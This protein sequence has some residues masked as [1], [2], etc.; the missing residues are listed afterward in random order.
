M[1]LRRVF[2]RRAT[3]EGVELM[4]EM[5]LVVVMPVDHVGPIGA[6]LEHECRQAA[7]QPLTAEQQP[8]RETEIAGTYALERTF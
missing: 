5:R 6:R 8:G 4:H 1:R 7:H 3:H 2:A